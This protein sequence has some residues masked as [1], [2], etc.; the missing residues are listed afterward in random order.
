MNN[1][2]QL[3]GKIQQKKNYNNKGGVHLPS[4]AIVSV[5]EI[6]ELQKQIIKIEQYWKTNTYDMQPLVSVLYRGIIA[7]SNRISIMFAEKA[8]EKINNLIVGAKFSKDNSPKHIITYLVTFEGL[9]RT[10]KILN[11]TKELLVNNFNGKIKSEDIE[12]INNKKIITDFGILN[13]TKFLGIIKDCY[14][15]KSIDIPSNFIPFEIE[16]EQIVTL[17]NVNININDLKNKIGFGHRYIRMLDEYT[18]LLNKGEYR[19]L[20][21]KAPDL[22]SMSVSD[23]RKN[24]CSH[25]NDVIRKKRRFILDPTN[26]PIIGVIDTL[27][28]ANVYF[29]KWVDAHNLL[30]PA[31]VERKDFYH[32]TAVSSLIVDGAELNREFDDGCGRFRVRHFGIAKD[33]K[34]SAFDITKQIKKIVLENKDIKVWNMSLGSIYSVD[35][36]SISPEAALLDKLQ[37]ENDVIFIIAGT[38]NEK[39]DGTYPKV[40]VP[41]DSI[42]SLVV[43]SALSNNFPAEYSRSGPILNFYNKPDVS[44]FGGDANKKIIVHSIY[45]DQEDYGTS[46]A[47]PWITRK[48]A[49]LIHKMGFSKEIAKALLVD[50]AAG[51]ESERRNQH[52]IGFGVVPIKIEDILSSRNDEIRFIIQ[53]RAEEYESYAYN[54]PV[55]KNK[56]GYPFVAKATLCYFPQCS[57]EQGVDYTDTELDIHFGRL[58][59]GRVMTINQN[60]Q[61]EPYP[62][63]LYEKDARIM[64]RKWDNIKHISEGYNEK[65]KPKQIYNDSDF[66][67]FRIN[68]KERLR[69]NEDRKLSYGLVI[70]LRNINGDNLI[71]EFIQRCF[72]SNWIVERLDINLLLENYNIAEEELVFEDDD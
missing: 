13:K 53:G 2:L 34:N 51:W 10:I 26:E 40:G 72:A 55:P 12:N 7:K 5:N 63:T 20:R 22:I 28:D 60:N 18:W 11:A 62:V 27:F 33:G 48:V 8:G 49:F 67:G 54:I 61:G 64:Y 29:S 4:S 43:N 19:I 42:N 9:E 32:G 21:E 44:A 38:N 41:A 14:Y 59:H 58:H 50:S 69:R 56:E 52:I 47:T 65:K 71:E 36:N 46:F 1:I 66:W 23:Y 30:D 37:Y 16:D 57:R 3:R 70:T 45:G 39:E 25:T 24:N 68:M 31:M 35:E 15:V 6:D 17:Y